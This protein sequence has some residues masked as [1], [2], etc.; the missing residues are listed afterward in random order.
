MTTPASLPVKLLPSNIRPIAYRIL[1]KKHGLNIQTDALS[2]LTETIS[3]KFGAEWRGTRAQQY[4]EEIAKVWKQQD[5]GLFIDGTG[6]KQVIKEINKEKERSKSVEPVRATRTDTVEDEVANEQELKVAVLNWEDFFKFITPDIQPN[7]R[8]DRVRKQFSAKPAVGAKLG[9]TL[10]L[11]VEYFSLRYHLIMDRLSRD[12]NFQ[13]TSFSSMA[14]I[15]TTLESRG[16]GT[17]DITLIKNVLGRDGNKFILFGLLSQNMNGNFIL[18]DSSDYIEL[19]M[20]QTYKTKGSFYCAGMCVI[21]EGIYSASGGSMSNDANVISGCFH[22]SNIG[23]PPAERREASLENYG[24]L[25]FMGIHSDSLSSSALVK[26]D[27][28]LKKK[29][30]AL[31]KVLVGHRLVML[32]CNCFLDDFKIMTGLKK[33]FAKLEDQLT[34]QQDRPHNEQEKQLAIIMTGSFVSRPLTATN[35]SLSL[36]SSSENYK[37]NFDNFAE[38]L[39]KYPL[40]VNSC[41]FVLIPGSNDPWQST[42]SLGRSSLNPLPQNPVPKVFV[43]RLER[44]LPKGNLILGWNPMRINYISQEIVLFRDDLM[45]KLKRNDIVFDHDLELERETL[46]KENSGKQLDI[47]NIKTDDVHL[48]AKV[49]QARQLVKTLLDQGHLQ[50]FLKDFRVVNP[51]YQH[52]MRIEPLP[53]SIALFDSRFECFE[54]TYNGCKVANLGNLVS[55]NNSRKF[56]YAEYTPSNKKYA[57][58]ELYF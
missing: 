39:S 27:K 5:R 6:L 16:K 30:S 17:Y 51:N 35:G 57:F 41:K 2:V 7:Y 56:N 18:E 36:I 10:F 28:A 14:A 53:T 37:N 43:T 54:V 50:P 3:S 45:N 31:E 40:V 44:L 33:L 12:E 19:N 29:L 46:R 25:D 20:S 47:E 8:F 23:H 52:V 13:K 32:G 55:N 34:E 9:S 42:H 11:S 15:N 22:V 48:S 4:I 21:V 26:V 58:K 38:L 49:K 24:H 1:S